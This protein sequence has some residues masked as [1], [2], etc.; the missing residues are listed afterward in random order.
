MNEYGE[1]TAAEIQAEMDAPSHPVYTYPISDFSAGVISKTAVVR[2][3][4]R[5]NPDLKVVVAGAFKI[6]HEKQCVTLELKTAKKV[7][8]GSVPGVAEVQRLQARIV[9][10]ETFEA[11]VMKRH[12]GYDKNN[13]LCSRPATPEQAM[14]DLQDDWDKLENIHV[15][16]IVELEA[17]LANPESNDE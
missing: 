1:K 12:N 16:R 7:V 6:D 8:P 5:L 10:L 13:E 17:K 14:Q 3:F 2:H 15:E 4:Q 9:E 11:A